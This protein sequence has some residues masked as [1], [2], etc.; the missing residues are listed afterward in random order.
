MFLG[1]ELGRVR[2]D[3]HAS[4]LGFELGRVWMD[5]HAMYFEITK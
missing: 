4:I 2:M 3:D 5:D 1:F